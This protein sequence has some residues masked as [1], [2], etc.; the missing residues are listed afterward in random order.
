MSIE[1][2]LNLADEYGSLIQVLILVVALITLVVII[3][4]HLPT[5]SNLL[6]LR[7]GEIEKAKSVKAE[8]EEHTK[9]DEVNHF[10]GEVVVY[11]ATRK[12]DLT[13]QHHSN[14]K[15]TAYW[16]VLTGITSDHL[17]FC[18]FSYHAKDI[19]QVADAWYSVEELGDDV[20]RVYA[21]Y[22]LEYDKIVDVDWTTDDAWGMPKIACDFS[23]P[24]KHPFC[25]AFYAKEETGLRRKFLRKICDIS[26][27]KELPEHLKQHE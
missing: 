8:F 12:L 10:F 21:T 5:R 26:E 14:K 15:A 2:L 6:K 20:I 25:E 27:V 24:T 16:L 4:P 1:P 18:S 3:W 13:E 17:E 23:T 11:D 19:K 9:W 22:L 7:K